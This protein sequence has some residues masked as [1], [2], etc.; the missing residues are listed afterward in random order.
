MT[1]LL[2]FMAISDSK[3][4]AVMRVLVSWNPLGA[5]SKDYPDLDSYRTE[6]SDILV[7]IESEKSAP[8]VVQD[9]ISGAFN[10]DISILDC[11]GPARE[12]WRIHTGQS[13]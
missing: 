11:Q 6:A 12:I 4:Q 13:C 10:I 9:V 7:E 3:I 2:K 8:K 1:N 5:R